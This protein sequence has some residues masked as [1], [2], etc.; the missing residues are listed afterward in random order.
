[1]A[2]NRTVDHIAALIVIAVIVYLLTREPVTEPEQAA[3]M[4]VP[5]H[6]VD[7]VTKQRWK[8]EQPHPARKRIS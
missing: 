6:D 2:V 1:M 4:P 3:V 7:E 8:E 5:N